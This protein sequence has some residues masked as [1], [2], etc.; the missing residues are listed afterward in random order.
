MTPIEAMDNILSMPEKVAGIVEK[1]RSE[2]AH[3][4]AQWH[5]LGKLG[6]KRDDHAVALLVTLDYRLSD[7]AGFATRIREQFDRMYKV[8]FPNSH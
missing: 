8:E 7:L 2:A 6:A 1:L 3:I 5:E 4:A